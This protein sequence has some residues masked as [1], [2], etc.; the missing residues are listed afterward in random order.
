LLG[1]FIG[2][3]QVTQVEIMTAKYVG[4]DDEFGHDV[5]ADVD[6]RFVS[7][8]EWDQLRAVN[9]IDDDGL[10]LIEYSDD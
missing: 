4:I 8:E 1:R 10:I 3:E 6:T 2:L 7:I 9:Y 5:W